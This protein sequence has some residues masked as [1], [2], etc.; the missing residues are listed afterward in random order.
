MNDPALV[1]YCLNCG[2]FAYA[3]SLCTPCSKKKGKEELV[4]FKLRS[5]EDIEADIK[6]LRAEY[7]LEGDR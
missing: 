1:G 6:R 5:K 4:T 7:S 3:Q 2:A